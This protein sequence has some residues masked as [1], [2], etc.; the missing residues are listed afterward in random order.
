MDTRS[1]AETTPFSRLKKPDP[2]DS[3]S[4]EASL[5]SSSTSLEICGTSE[6]APSALVESS[7]PWRTAG[8]SSPSCTGWKQEKV[9][10]SSPLRS[11]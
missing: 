2:A 1:T 6:A 8:D 5:T 7:L 9:W 10:F 4:R 11:G 3:Y